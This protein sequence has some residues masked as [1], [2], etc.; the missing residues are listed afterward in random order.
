[1]KMFVDFQIRVFF[2]EKN[3]LQLCSEQDKKVTIYSQL[4]VKACKFAIWYGQY[5]FLF[6]EA[7]IFI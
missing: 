4:T 2:F 6:V 5:S 3:W 7:L 1:L